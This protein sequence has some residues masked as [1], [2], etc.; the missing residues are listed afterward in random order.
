MQALLGPAELAMM[1]IVTAQVVAIAY[2][3]SPRSKSL[4][5]MLPIPFSTALVT[6]GRG[7][8]ATHLL[9]MAV[10]WAFPW[11]AWYLHGRRGWPVLLAD[12]CGVLLYAGATLAFTSLVPAQAGLGTPWFTAAAIVL[13]A[14]CL[15]AFGFSPPAEPG[16]RSRLPVAFKAAL[17]LG[18]IAA[19][20]AL[21]KPMRGFMPAF[22]LATIFTVYEARH[23]LK[24]LSMRFPIFLVG[25][26]GMAAVMAWLLPAGGP[27]R[28]TAYLLPLAAG[29]AVYVPFYLLLDR[30][31][32]Q[33]SPATA[34]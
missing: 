3:S 20:L 11:L 24:T 19:L 27:L 33:R 9:G 13:L 23:S 12:A 7:I 28:P 29:W 6:T 8:D 18:L 15:P 5:Y 14:A 17:I 4:V 34:A 1:A 32:T 25:F 10:V 21:R 2:L 31:Y 30:W 26:I 22:P 16:H